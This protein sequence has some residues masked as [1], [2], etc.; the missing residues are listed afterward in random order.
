MVYT[1][2][3]R[4]LLGTFRVEFARSLGNSRGHT[5]TRQKQDKSKTKAEVAG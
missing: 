2:I 4:F 5:T 3:L 1:V